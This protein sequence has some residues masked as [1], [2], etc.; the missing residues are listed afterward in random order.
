[1][2]VRNAVQAAATKPSEPFNPTIFWDA[3]AQASLGEYERLLTEFTPNNVITFG[4]FAFAFGLRA[5]SEPHAGN[6]AG[7]TKS[8]LLGNEFRKRV[9]A[10]DIS[11][12]NVLPLL[13]R[14]IAGGSFFAGHDE[15][16]GKNGGNCFDEAGKAIARILVRHHEQLDCWV[17]RPSELGVTQPT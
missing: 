11:R 12:T 1:M 7:G 8:A 14:S 10:F 4:W 6:T 5:T 17:R 15:F 16:C 3:G 9:E 2:Y 13:H